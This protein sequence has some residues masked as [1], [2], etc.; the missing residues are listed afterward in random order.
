MSK[1]AAIQMASSPSVSS[2]LLEA[3]KL[4]AEAAHAGAKLVALPENF[5]LMG[6][7]EL[8]KIGV[9]EPEGTGPIQHFLA[10]VAKKY[11][12]WVVGGTIPIAGDAANKVRAACLVYDDQ[13]K[14]VARYD[15][16]HLFDVNVPGTNE[17]YRESDSIEPGE[18]LKVF[19]TPFGR[20]GLAVCYDLRFPEFFRKMSEQKVDIIFLPSAFTAETGA[21]HWELLVRA[22][23]IEN[24]CYVIAP[25]QGG[26]HLNGRKTFG[27]SM[28][29]DPWGI[30]LDCQKTGS[31]FVM[32]DIDL[33][34]LEKVRAVFP[35]LNHRRFI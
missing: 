25:N 14:Q 35:V 9:K 32:A 11:A 16:I 22:R 1:C 4:I 5:A 30:V 23:A 6:D 26:F 15:K 19:D 12:V 17:V 10:T 29:V 2:N 20:L 18:E 28:I 8:D 7:N 24:L 27:H 13:G 3:E 31:G 33:E 34:R 21:A